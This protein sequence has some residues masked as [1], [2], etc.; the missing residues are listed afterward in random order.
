VLAGV[1]ALLAL[2]AV[3]VAVAVILIV[4]LEDDANELSQR[5]VL[6]AAAIHEAALSAKGMANDQ[7]GYLLSGRPALTS[8]RRARTRRAEHRGGRDLRGR[9]VAARG[10]P[11]I[12]GRFRALVA[13]TNATSQPT[14]AARERRSRPARPD[15]PA[16]D[17][18]SS[19]RERVHA[20][21]ALIDSATE[22]LVL[23]P[24]SVTILLAYLALAL[25]VGV[26]V[27]L[28]SRAVLKPAF[29]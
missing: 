4:S 3:A 24:R 5:H 27:A 6:Y 15:A 26:G 23:R 8:C 16:A 18:T 9:G 2:L 11:G 21:H 14:A 25:V 29:T 13:G 10:R 7:R 22:S 20:R 17:L 19:H 1:G 12:A 28:G